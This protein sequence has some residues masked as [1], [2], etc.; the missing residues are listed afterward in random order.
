MRAS[1]AR[2]ARFICHLPA[3]QEADAFLAE[4]S[5]SRNSPI[6]RPENGEIGEEA[7]EVLS[8]ARSKGPLFRYAKNRALTVSGASGEAHL[9]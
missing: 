5:A 2:A 8:R 4:A 7:P 1:E 6:I 3:M 9:G